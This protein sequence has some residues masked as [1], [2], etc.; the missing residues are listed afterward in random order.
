MPPAP[1]NRYVDLVR[2]GA[3]AAVLLGHWLLTD[4]TYR[5]GR[6]SGVD[7]LNYIDWGR[8]SRCCSR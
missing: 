4:V 6:L 1:R 3:I 2:V 8:G 7:A 5:N